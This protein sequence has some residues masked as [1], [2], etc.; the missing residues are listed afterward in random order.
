M[1]LNTNRGVFARDKIF[2]AHLRVSK[3]KNDPTIKKDRIIIVPSR[4]NSII[5]CHD[6]NVHPPNR[7][8]L[9]RL[10]SPD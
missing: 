1:R 9:V 6:A 10:S 2:R 3:V 8:S 4:I 5:R 7:Q